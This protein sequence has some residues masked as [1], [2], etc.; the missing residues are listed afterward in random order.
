MKHHVDFSLPVLVV[1]QEEFYRQEIKKLLSRY[2]VQ[3]DCAAKA[4]NASER[5]RHTKYGL[6]IMDSQFNPRSGLDFL[7]ENSEE[8]SGVPKVVMPIILNPSD[9]TQYLEVHQI[10]DIISKLGPW[11]GKLPVAIEWEKFLQ[12]NDRAFFP[13]NP[14]FARYEDDPEFS[15]YFEWLLCDPFGV[16]FDSSKRFSETEMMVLQLRARDCH[17]PEIEETLLKERADWIL[18]I[19]GEVSDSGTM[20]QPHPSGQKL[21]KW[22]EEGGYCPFVFF[23]H[24]FI[25]E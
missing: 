8:L 1:E 10:D 16:S 20:E 23:R 13:D 3:V 5:L 19:A 11:E 12:M 22:G 21:I 15:Q 25:E 2:F 24:F 4:K 18:M 17:E 14:W 7:R 6:V 9:K